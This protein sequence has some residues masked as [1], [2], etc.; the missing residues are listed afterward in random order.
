MRYLNRLERVGT[1]QNTIPD[2]LERCGFSK[3]AK[4]PDCERANLD[5]CEVDNSESCSEG[6]RWAERDKLDL[7][8]SSRLHVQM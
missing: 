2:E 6:R 7:F 8:R 4:A 3:K 5:H 1:V